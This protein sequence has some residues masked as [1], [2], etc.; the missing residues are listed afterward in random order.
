MGYKRARVTVEELCNDLQLG[1]N[2]S[3]YVLERL[4][5][6]IKG[7]FLYTEHL[8]EF[9]DY[10]S[11]LMD[12]LQRVFMERIGI[13]LHNTPEIGDQLRPLLEAT[14]VPMAVALGVPD[15]AFTE[16]WQILEEPAQRLYTPNDAPSQAHVP[17]SLA[18]KRWGASPSRISQLREGLPTNKVGRTR[19]V[20]LHASEAMLEW[21]LVW[22]EGVPRQHLVSD[23]QWV[24]D[25]AFK[26]LLGWD[27]IC[28]KEYGGHEVVPAKGLHMFETKYV[29]LSRRLHTRIAAAIVGYSDHHRRDVPAEVQSW[30]DG[31]EKRLQILETLVT[32]NGVIE[33]FVEAV[34]KALPLRLQLQVNS[35]NQLQKEREGR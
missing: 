7:N 30:L 9:D 4:P 16:M 19:L 26:A 18:A 34:R 5:K 10:W 14:V 29:A 17:T 11:H 24:T 22:S 15:D 25:T 3:R 35:T 6:P 33:E 2:L 13:L 21:L 32:F 12:G 8:I 1:E 27:W 20:D 28:V 23:R 31:R